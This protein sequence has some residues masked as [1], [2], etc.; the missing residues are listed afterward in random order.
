MSIEEDFIFI[1]LKLMIIPVIFRGIVLA[2]FSSCLP[3]CRFA[4]IVEVNAS[5]GAKRQRRPNF[6]RSDFKQNQIKQNSCILHLRQSELQNKTNT[7]EMQ[8]AKFRGGGTVSHVTQNKN[9]RPLETVPWNGSFL[10]T[11]C[12]DYKKETYGF[13]V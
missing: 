1:V 9:H 6:Y 7:Q 8:C 10:A 12:T 11:T 13:C 3:S 5:D 2:H 4:M